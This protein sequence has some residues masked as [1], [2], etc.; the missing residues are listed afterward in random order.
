MYIH[1]PAFWQYR[2]IKYILGWYMARGHQKYM[3][4]PEKSYLIQQ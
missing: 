4:I 2:Q 3:N 1:F